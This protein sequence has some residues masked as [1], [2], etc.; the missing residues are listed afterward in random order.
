[1]GLHRWE[2]FRKSTW[3]AARY[4]KCFRKQITKKVAKV[5]LEKGDFF[6]SRQKRKVK[7]YQML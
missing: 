2:T 4:C 6:L 7:K 1:M 5:E 3:G